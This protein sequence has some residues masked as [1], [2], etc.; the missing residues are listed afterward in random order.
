M[1]TDFVLRVDWWTCS[2]GA[3]KYHGEAK[4]C[5]EKN[6]LDPA[7]IV[8]SIVMSSVESLIKALNVHCKKTGIEAEEYHFTVSPSIKYDT[9][10][11]LLPEKWAYLIAYAIEGGSEGYYVHVGAILKDGSGCFGGAVKLPSYMDFGFCKTYS[12]DSAYAIARE[13]QRFLT[14]AQWN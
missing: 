8:H 4:T 11:Q 12:A 14:A 7:T 1:I 6:K 9:P 13:A 5:C 3:Y 2:L 10:G